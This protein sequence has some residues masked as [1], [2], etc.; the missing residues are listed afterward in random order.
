MVGQAGGWEWEWWLVG[1]GGVGPVWNWGVRV[2][3][4]DPGILVW[5]KAVPALERLSDLETVQD[6][7]SPATVESP[8]LVQPCTAHSP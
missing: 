1:K 5:A 3:N 2:P 6:C 8:G 4:E 7:D